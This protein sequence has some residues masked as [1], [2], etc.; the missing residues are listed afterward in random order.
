[1]AAEQAAGYPVA[2]EFL[3]DAA[4]GCCSLGIHSKGVGWIGQKPRVDRKL[5]PDSLLEE[6]GR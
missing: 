6:L 5:S 1:M 2:G 4:K 3:L